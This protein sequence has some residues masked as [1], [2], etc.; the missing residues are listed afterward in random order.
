MVYKFASGFQVRGD[1]QVIGDRLEMIRVKRG[2]RLTA[3]D[4]LA[5]GTRKTSPLHD[6]FEWRDSVAA[7]R[8]RLSQAGYL[9]RAVVVA[10]DSDGEPFTPV[11]AFVA[12]SDDDTE[13]GPQRFTHICQAMRDEATCEDVISRAKADLDA[14]RARYAALRAFADVFAAIDAMTP[15]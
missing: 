2:G 11:R 8:Y 12:V 3:Q 13:N 5:D 9:I 4:V 1:P 6:H 14:W 15:A 7:E 10:A